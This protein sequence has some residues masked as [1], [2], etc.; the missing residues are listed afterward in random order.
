MALV[1]PQGQSTVSL[2]DSAPL[3]KRDSIHHHDL[4]SGW[5][6]VVGSS[7]WR[8][9]NGSLYTKGR[10]GWLG[11]VQSYLHYCTYANDGEN[12]SRCLAT[13]SNKTLAEKSCNHKHEMLIWEDVSAS[14]AFLRAEMAEIRILGRNVWATGFR[15]VERDAS[16]VAAVCHVTYIFAAEFVDPGRRWG[17]KV[18]PPLGGRYDI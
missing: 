13:P 12:V 10:I 4:G 15:R 9:S 11:S 6:L 7:P 14:P 16:D 3:I 1:S 18:A 8:Q 2:H 5:I 17:W